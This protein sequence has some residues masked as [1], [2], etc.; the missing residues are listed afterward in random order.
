MLL[1][2]DRGAALELVDCVAT[3]IEGGGAV[4]RGGKNGNRYI[5]DPDFADSM[6]DCK[7][8][9]TETM[10]R[11]GADR[12][13]LTQGHPLEGFVPQRANRAAAL[14]IATYDAKERCN[15]AVRTADYGLERTRV[16]RL[17]NDPKHR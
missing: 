14:A 11:F 2:P 3:G 13:E 10:A 5:A 8:Y 4:R 6:D 12:L 17:A 7:T 1:F 16:D 15:A 9:V